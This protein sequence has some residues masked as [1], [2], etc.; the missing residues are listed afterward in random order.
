MSIVYL[1]KNQ[2]DHY[3]NRSGEWVTAENHKTLFHTKHKDEA[4]N[5]KAEFSVKNAELRIYIFERS[6]DDTDNARLSS[7]SV[8]EGAPAR[9]HSSKDTNNNQDTGDDDTGPLRQSM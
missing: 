6:L 3:L 7:N 1:L 9:D 4:V 5:V 2:H 8:T